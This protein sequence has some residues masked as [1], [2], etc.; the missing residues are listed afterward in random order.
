M[1]ERLDLFNDD[2]ADDFADDFDDDEES[3]L[4]TMN[5]ED[6]ESLV[7]ENKLLTEFL[8]KLGYSNE[9][10]QSISTTGSA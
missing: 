5:R 8:K 2:F 10:L 3:E 9:E 7:S 4:I 1:N 6:Y